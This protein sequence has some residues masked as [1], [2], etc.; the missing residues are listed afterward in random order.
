MTSLLKP[1]KKALK[2]FNG[3]ETL[4]KTQK[5]INIKTKKLDEIKSIK[6]IDFLKMDIQGSELDVLKNG[7]KK[8]NQCVAIQLEVSFICL[9]KNQ[10]SFGKVDTWLR[11]KGFV[12]HCFVNVKKWS[13]SPTIKNNDFR[14]PFNQLL[15]GDILYIK[16][17]IV[18]HI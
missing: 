13:I 18:H 3:F 7:E 17:N 4:G 9:Y 6:K 1:D 16:I 14:Q 11:K 15:E 5:N 10:P 12:P 8:I 2:Y